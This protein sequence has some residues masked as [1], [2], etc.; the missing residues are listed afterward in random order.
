MKKPFFL[1]LLAISSLVQAQYSING[2]MTPPHKNDWVILYK[3]EGARQ[4]FIKNTTIKKDTIVIDGENKLIGRFNFDL[5]ENAKKGSY[6]TTYALQGAGFVDFLFNKENIS[7]TFNP[8]YPEQS[9]TFSKSK[10]NQLYREYLEAININQQKLD[11]LQMVALRNPN[12]SIQT[13][14]KTVLNSVND[15]QDIYLKKSENMMVNHFMK[16]TLRKNSPEVFTLMKNYLSNFIDTFFDNM[17]FNDKVL[18]NSS[19]LIDRISNYIF[20]LNYSKDPNLSKELYKKSITKVMSKVSDKKF[21]K[22]VIEFL[23]TQFEA[24]KNIELVD[25][26]FDNYYKKLPETLQNK[27]FKTDILSKLVAEVGR[28]A[29]DFS[30]KEG[31]KT[32]KL[33][34]L[35]GSKYYVLTFWSTGCSHCLREIPQ[36]HTFMKDKTNTKVISFAMEKD[37]FGWKNYI[38]KLNGWHNVL[39]LGKW[40]NKTARTYQVFS[41]PTYLILDINKKII[42]KPDNIR[43][44]KEFFIKKE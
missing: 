19:F 26:L 16:A 1:I 20:D 32:Y 5:P 28:I 8:S 2:T 14:Y 18:Y 12:D 27:K 17:N 31:N 34:T 40:E 6:R 10:E 11:S 29:P 21:K 3:I 43:E 25:Y 41:T 13:T 30:W 23:I 24:S 4:V 36:L 39:G 35:K 38:Y 42:A 15:V 44:L 33:S 9:V 37:S 22:D 7:F